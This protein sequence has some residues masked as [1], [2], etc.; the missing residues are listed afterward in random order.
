MMLLM[1]GGGKAPRKLMGDVVV[2]GHG[3]VNDD[4]DYVPQVW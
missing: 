4:E 3:A 1:L 2:G